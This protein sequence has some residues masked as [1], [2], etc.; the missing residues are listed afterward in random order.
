MII[1]VLGQHT[2]LS[3]QHSKRRNN[4]YFLPLS[5]KSPAIL[6]ASDTAEET[7]AGRNLEL[8]VEDDSDIRETA[9]EHLENSG[10]TVVS[11]ANKH[12]RL[13]LTRTQE[14]IKFEYWNQ[15]FRLD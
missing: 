12:Y 6:D 11:A 9:V 3:S 10:F 1:K 14:D 5:H 7:F 8:L 15:Y 2:A 4:L 13:A